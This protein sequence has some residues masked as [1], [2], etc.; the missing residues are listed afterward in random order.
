M[1]FFFLSPV[2]IFSKNKFAL[3]GSSKNNRFH[4]RNTYR[5]RGTEAWDF[6]KL[7]VLI[8]WVPV[9]VIGLRGALPQTWRDPWCPATWPPRAG[10]WWRSCCPLASAEQQKTNLVNFSFNL[11]PT[12][13]LY[14]KLSWEGVGS[15]VFS[16]QLFT[17]LLKFNSSFT[18]KVFKFLKEK[19]IFC[20][21]VF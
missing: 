11:E 21:A 20:V 4:V 16:L 18:L 5:Y 14:G 8:T 7:P 15:L 3:S 9:R 1:L 10:C 13:S 6:L 17:C 19:Y 12:L 2:H